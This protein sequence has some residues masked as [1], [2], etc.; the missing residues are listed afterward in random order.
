MVAG[1]EGSVANLAGISL[2][3]DNVFANDSAAFQ[4]V[5]V[6][7]NASNGF[8]ARLQVGIAA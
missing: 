1:Y 5:T 4:L 3:G 2:A 7:G 8:A 6:T